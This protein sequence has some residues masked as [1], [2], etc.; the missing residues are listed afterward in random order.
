KIVST[1]SVWMDAI[2]LGFG[3]ISQKIRKRSFYTTKITSQ[4]SEESALINESSSSSQENVESRMIKTNFYPWEKIQNRDGSFFWNKFPIFFV[5]SICFILIGLIPVISKSVG[6]VTD[7][8]ATNWFGAELESFTKANWFWWTSQY[9]RTAISFTI[10]P[11]NMGLLLVGIIVG[12]IWV[13]PALRRNKIF[14][15][16]LTFLVGFPLTFLGIGVHKWAVW[17][18]A[19]N[20]AFRLLHPLGYINLASFV[21]NG[22]PILFWLFGFISIIIICHLFNVKIFYVL[23]AWLHQI[24]NG[25]TIA[26]GLDEKKEKIKPS[27]QPLSSGNTK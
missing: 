3:K 1:F 21:L 25:I 11:F 14:A 24:I 19:N 6:L 2:G 17:S 13:T 5:I 23:Y 10:N 12:L 22:I 18:V 9:K 27:I 7:L 20:D 8:I 4:N 16:I 15:T 26:L